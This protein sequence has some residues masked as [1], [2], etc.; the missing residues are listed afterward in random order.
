MAWPYD[1]RHYT[2]ASGIWVPCATLNEMEDKI[3]DL[4]SDH[5]LITMTANPGWDGSAPDW[6]MDATNPEQ[7]WIPI[8]LTPHL[9]FNLGVRQSLVIKEITV[10]Y[11]NGHPTTPGKPDVVLYR[12]D[13]KLSNDTTAPV[14]GSALADMTGVS[15]I[16]NGAW[17]V[18]TVSGLSVSASA[19]TRLLIVAGMIGAATLDRLAAL[20]L[21]VQPLTAT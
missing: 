20:K 16:A 14:L 9:F 18:R 7:G 11:Y 6:E 19:G 21:T 4:F 15:D 5:E 12:P 3:V 13:P 1:A 8:G 10:K 17:G 2:F